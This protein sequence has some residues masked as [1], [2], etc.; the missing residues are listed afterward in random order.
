M[1]TTLR[2]RRSLLNGDTKHIYNREEKKHTLGQRDTQGRTKYANKQQ[3]VIG[4]ISYIQ[5][6]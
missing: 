5:T 6:K 1:S 2:S 3:D 4:K